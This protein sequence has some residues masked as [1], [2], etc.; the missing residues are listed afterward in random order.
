MK[1]KIEFILNNERV[2]TEVNPTTS[3]LDFLRNEKHLTGVKS[4]CREGD[5]GAC[6]VLLGSIDKGEMNYR[7]VASCIF[8]LGKVAGKHIVTIEGL[9]GNKLNFIQH[10]F[11]EENAAQCGF[12]TP[13][14]IISLTAFMLNNSGYDYSEAEKAVAG[15]VCR[16]TG[17]GSIKRA[18]RNMTNDI[19]SSNEDFNER[20]S[21]LIER[22]VV[23]EYF[24]EIPEMLM[25]LNNDGISFAGEIIVGGG[26]DIYVQKPDAIVE[27]NPLFID[28]EKF[29]YINETDTEII[30]GGGT[31]FEKFSESP[32]INK[33]FPSIKNDSVLI[34]SL[35]IRNVATIAGNIV[36]ASPIG[37]LSI[38][39][40][41]LNAKLKLNLNE[42]TRVISLRDFYLGYKN[43]DKAPLE[44]ITEIII[45]KPQRGSKFNF[46]KVS[47]RLHLDIA[48][49]NSAATLSVDENIIVSASVAAGGVA[50]IP[51]YLEE[52]S[53]FL[54][55]RVITTETAELAAEI[56][57][58]E[59]TPID[60]VR[61]SAEYKKL[62]LG[63]LIKTHFVELFLEN[64]EIG[65]L[66]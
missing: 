18:I 61:G 9:N 50:P 32:L 46:E 11:A 29:S 38:I 13:G 14:Y 27:M 36:N 20:L 40:L 52:T 24:L 22:E 60:D 66:I 42:V 43:I 4:V 45:P 55:G 49:V 5:C 57:M 26:T 53:K 51:K 1:N 62:L 7:N 31:T 37:D 59:V 17:Y 41:A 56:A 3:L 2:I 65:V 64:I 21:L 15:N 10:H 8:P 35:L 58:N 63:Q 47:K 30:I 28:E 33:F 39:L 44:I 34:A 19:Q 16:C 12:C 54:T 25:E 6:S 23:P 48:S